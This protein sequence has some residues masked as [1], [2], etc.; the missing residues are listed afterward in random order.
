MA[1]PLERIRTARNAFGLIREYIGRPTHIPDDN[2]TAKDLLDKHDENS[3]KH[4]APANENGPGKDVLDLPP[5]FAPCES[6]SAF[7][8]VD[9]ASNGFGKSIEDIEKLINEVLL[10]DD[11]D[12]EDVKSFSLS[13]EMKRLDNADTD[14]VAAT[15]I[16]PGTPHSGQ[17]WIHTSV[18]IPVPDTGNIHPPDD[19]ILFEV[20]NLALRRIIPIITDAFSKEN[21][22]SFHY[23]PF[24][25]YWQ[26][27]PDSPQQQVYNEIYTTDKFIR[28]HEEVNALPRDP[29]DHHERVVVPLMLWSDSTRLANFGDASL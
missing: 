12:L 21:A 8:L 6:A 16:N 5:W 25:H 22:S 4:T 28:M 15:A 7:R 2:I 27:S 11:F 18:K 1:E 20:D 23:T 24:Y 26:P 10:A 29:D 3:N 14:R 19:Q 17:G 13:K 9:W